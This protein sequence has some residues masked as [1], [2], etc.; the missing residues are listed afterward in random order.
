VR[1]LFALCAG[2]TSRGGRGEG[3]IG[4][5]RWHRGVCSPFSFRYLPVCSGASRRSA[6]SVQS[7]GAP[8]G[9]PLVGNEGL[10]G[11]QGVASARRRYLPG[12][13]GASRRS[14][15]SAKPTVAPSGAPLVGYEG[16][17]G[18]Q[19]VASAR[20]LPPFAS[21]SRLLVDS[22]IQAP[23]RGLPVPAPS[24]GL[25]VPAPN[26]GLPVPARTP[27]FPVPAPG[28]SS[29]HS[30]TFLLRLSACLNPL[31]VSLLTLLLRGRLDGRSVRA[32]SL[33]R[34]PSEI[35]G[36]QPPCG[37]SCFLGRKGLQLRRCFRRRSCRL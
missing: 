30:C 25:P 2:S 7:D 10:L 17:W 1:S 18:N 34:R 37:S 20:R 31:R 4:A 14:A 26:R 19:G 21:S 36:S 24:R 29:I 13:S 32:G 9:A 33:H 15:P 23:S 11:N 6:P 3:V 5:Q 8:N 12:C 35:V 28:L 27:G 22:S 16:L